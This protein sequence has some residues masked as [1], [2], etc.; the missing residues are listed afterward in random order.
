MR[1]VNIHKTQK[2][3]NYLQSILKHRV[4]TNVIKMTGYEA[5]VERHVGH[6]KEGGAQMLKVI[7]AG[8]SNVR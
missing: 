6:I 3:Y 4:F 5:W 2:H 8:L 1:F 7:C